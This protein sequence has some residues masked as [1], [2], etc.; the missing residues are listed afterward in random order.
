MQ[1]VVREAARKAEKEAKEE[2]EEMARLEAERGK[3]EEKMEEKKRIVESKQ[4]FGKKLTI[5]STEI[6]TKKFGKSRAHICSE[7]Q[8]K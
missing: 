4:K 5:L 6:W 2:A 1:R 3:L 8:I 7:M